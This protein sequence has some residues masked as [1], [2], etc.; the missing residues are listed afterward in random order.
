MIIESATKN[1]CELLGLDVLQ[2]RLHDLL[3]RRRYLLVLDDVWNEDHDEWDKL[4]TFLRSGAAGSKIIVTTRSS[5]VA[6]IMGSMP[7]HHLEGLSDDDCWTLFKHRAFSLD[8]DEVFPSLLPIGKRIVQ[9]CAGVPLAAKTLGSLM[10]FKR[11]EREWLFVQESELWNACEGENGIFP[12]LRLSF[13][14]LPPHLKR[15]FAY[16]SILP[17]K[18]VIKKEKLIHQWIAEGLIQPSKESNTPEDIGNE[19]FNDLTWMFFFQDVKKS[20][21][22]D[23]TECKMHDL[24]H[25][26]AQTIAGNEFVILEDGRIPSNLAQIRHSSV[27]CNFGLPTIPEALYK[28]EKLR[29]LNVL[30][31]IGDL[32][33]API[34]LFSSFRHLRV[35]DL[36]GSG[37]RKLHNL[38]SSLISLRYLD[39]SYTLV[40]TL[41]ETICSLVNLQVLNLYGCYDLIELPGSLTSLLK[42]RHL[43]I[44]GCERLTQLPSHIEKLYELQ[45]LPMYIVGNENDRGLL[46]L[47]RL[48]LKGELNIRRLENVKFAIEARLAH[49]ERK[50]NL[51]S[52][53]LSWGNEHVGLK[54]RN[55][56]DSRL[57]QEVLECLKPHQ[58]LKSLCIKGFPGNCFPRWMGALQLPNLIKIVL[59]DCKRCEHLPTLGRLPFLEIL[60]MHAMDAVN[61]IGNEFYG[62]GAGRPFMS[63]KELSLSDFP[64]LAYWWSMDGREEFPFLVKL[65]IN[66]CPGLMNMPCFPSLRHLE[67]RNCNEMI[68][69]SAVTLTLLSTL[70]IDVF[71]GELVLLESLLQNNARLMSLTVSS[72]PDL[73]SISS[74]LGN[75]I[76]LESLTIRWCEKLLFLPQELQSLTSLESLEISDCHS[77]AALPESIKGLSSLRSLSIENC[78]NLTSIPMGLQDLTALEHLTIMYCPTLASF[79][80]DLRYLSMLKSV[81]ILSCPELA[82]LPEGLKHVKTLQNLEIHSCP[83]FK[84]LP[85]W[86][87]N[88]DFLRSLT[89]SDCHNIT[90][91]P[92]GLQRLNTLQHLSIR[93]CPA[94]EERCKENIGEDWPKIAHV[95]HTYIGSPEVRQ[96]DTASSSA[97]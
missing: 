55:C 15:C 95:A 21:Y 8:E 34:N 72:C 90:S 20:S 6:S 48:Q 16:C 5:K 22:G 35:L 66:N 44:N 74:N 73:H 13:S 41:P 97:R 96:Q 65:T 3:C 12:A 76:F 79:P 36:S 63:L 81:F 30:F 64:H 33:E 68:L 59:I 87:E 38:I 93:Q 50:S 52:L 61:N 83:G 54:M 70:V 67:L 80:T 60:H 62:E 92:D 49:L 24:I 58:N 46:Q 51:H 29:T 1:K 56:G 2:S 84:D 86:I 71:K 17:K 42:L 25:D 23:I 57:G 78:S 43:I 94:L 10:R 14:H 53:G 28:V 85:K 88:L 91:L 7:P 11:E 4:R 47:S 89:I 77:L 19:Y 27:V 26:L 18:Y 39:L 45:T 82:S 40:E 69:R 37:I 75:L 32:K 31:S 9:K